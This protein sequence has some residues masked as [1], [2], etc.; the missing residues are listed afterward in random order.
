MDPGSTRR[1]FLVLP[2]RS[3]EVVLA[4]SQRMPPPAVDKPLDHLSA[5]PVVR[6]GEV[7]IAED[8]IAGEGALTPQ[9]LI[10]VAGGMV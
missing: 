8:W 6:L 2:M 9:R 5:H 7:S 10:C 1:S 4:Q 3:R